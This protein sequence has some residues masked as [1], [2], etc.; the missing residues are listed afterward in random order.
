MRQ[1][2]YL[3]AAGLYALK[4]N[5]SRLKDDHIHAQC[6]AVALKKNVLIKEVLDTPT[7]IVIAKTA[8]NEIRDKLLDYYRSEKL[9]AVPFGDNTFRMVTHIN[10]TRQMTERATEIIQSSGISLL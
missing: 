3:A 9:L 8:N 5:I 4:N 2:G 6:L 10:I 7:N 1:A